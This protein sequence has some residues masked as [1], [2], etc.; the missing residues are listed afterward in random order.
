MPRAVSRSLI[1]WLAAFSLLLNGLLPGVAQA[2]PAT[3]ALEMAICSV[4]GATTPDQQHGAAAH[5]LACC[6]HGQVLALPA[7]TAAIPVRARPALQPA[8]TAA[9]TRTGAQPY[10][11][12]RPRGPPHA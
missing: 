9:A 3:P 5:C 6:H 1:A 8:P 11:R 4:A 12:A 10:R 2:M 7:T